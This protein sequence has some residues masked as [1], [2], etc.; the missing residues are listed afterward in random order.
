MRPVQG[1][2]PQQLQ[3]VLANIGEFDHVKFTNW[4]WETA[5]NI[6]KVAMN[7]PPDR[8]Y[9]LT[10]GP[11]PTYGFIEAYRADGMV[12]VTLLGKIVA[13]TV[14]AELL[15]DVTDK[16]YSGEISPPILG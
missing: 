2:F 16:A 6:R 11:V 4:L 10:T 9:R 14:P 7:R 12:S 1:S 13:I 15:E 8:L 5:P 3:A